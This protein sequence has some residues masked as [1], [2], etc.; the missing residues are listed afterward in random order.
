MLCIVFILLNGCNEKKNS[1]ANERSGFFSLQ[2]VYHFENNPKDSLSFFEAD[3]IIDASTFFINKFKFSDTVVIDNNV[4]RTIAFGSDYITGD[5]A[6]LRKLRDTLSSDGLQVF[7]DYK[8]SIPFRG[9]S[10]SKAGIYYPVY[11]VNETN[12]DKFFTARDRYVSAIQE[13]KD[14]NQQWRP[15][16]SKRFDFVGN[17][18]WGLIIHPKEFALFITAKYEGSYKTLLRVRMKIGD[19]IY[20]TKAFEGSINE[21]QFHLKPGS[22]QYNEYKNNLSVS[23]TSRF[24]GSPPL[25]TEKK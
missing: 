4:N 22:Y 11:V 9:S 24:L 23:L 10:F 20:M 8:I 14:K 17:G 19:V 16:E 13:A 25:D 18:R 21:N 3:N 1:V 6:S 12:S 5:S 2:H 7:A 15:I